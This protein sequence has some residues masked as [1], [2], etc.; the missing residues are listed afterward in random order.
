M[1]GYAVAELALFD[2]GLVGGQVNEDPVEEV[3]T[4]QVGRHFPSLLV[5][6]IG[7]DRDYWVMT[8]QGEGFGRR[9]HVVPPQGRVAVGREGDVSV[10]VGNAEGVFARYGGAVG[11]G[12]GG[13]MHGVVPPLR[14]G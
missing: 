2:G 14:R 1:R 10:G 13:E 9:G 11:K 4:G 12:G 8:E 7:L 6:V 5:D 3:G